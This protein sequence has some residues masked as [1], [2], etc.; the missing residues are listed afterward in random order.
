MS[1][2][3]RAVAVTGIG[4]VSS[5][6]N[7]WGS[8]WQ[9]CIEG[10]TLIEPVPTYWAQY[11]ES[12]SNYW[13]PLELPDYS[14]MG[15]KRSDVLSIDPAALNAM[16]AAEQ[17]ISGSS[18][19][20][21][22]IDERSGRYRIE[23]FDEYRCGAFIGTGLG[24][25]TSTFQNY[26][27]H[28]LGRFRKEL[29]GFSGEP[30]PTTFARELVANIET[31]PRVLPVAS[32]KSMANS[33]SAQIAIRNGLKGPNETCMAACAAGASA[34]ARAY[35]LIAF[36]KLDFALAGGT[37]Y[38]GDRAGGV[39]M[40]FDRLNTL[41]K[42]ERP[43]NE[44]NRPFDRARSGFLFS[45]GG[46]CVLALECADSAKA[47]GVPILAFLKGSSTTSDAFSLAALAPGGA[48]IR[49][50]IGECI[51]DAGIGADDI[52]YVNAHGTA[53]VQND[54]LEAAIIDDAFRN[55]PFINATKSLLGHTI[56]ACGAIEAAVSAFSI[57][58][59]EL[60]PNLNL[61]SPIRDL[62]FVQER[63]RANICSAF[64][65]N[66]GFGGHNVGL[67]FGRD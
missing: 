9:S 32:T 21:S 19:E 57:Y 8:F 54:E 59:G 43:G 28:L 5:L 31:Q 46:A 40:A 58:S 65:Q 20:K 44:I 1:T 48:A 36:G 16:Y 25:I 64:T 13:S 2:T 18:C 14:L 42:G 41:A 6:G 37:E 49:R 52:D 66:F 53:T 45:Q 51:A 62:N 23:S 12:K 24:C 67:I 47:R 11:Y 27:P 4:V 30:S 55:K 63:Q 10:K 26:V 50:M 22:I 35:E 17:A 60:H 61:D 56:G 34:I 15:L 38:Y 29:D 39:F 33:I 7:D 3:R